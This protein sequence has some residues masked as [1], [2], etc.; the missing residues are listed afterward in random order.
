[1]T[2]EEIKATC[3][4][5]HTAFKKGYMSRK[6]EDGIINEYSGR[7]GKGYTVETPAYNTNQYH[8]ITYYIFKE[9]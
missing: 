4:E 7:Y 9:V 2:I 3:N 1:M 5:H 6:L 8:Y